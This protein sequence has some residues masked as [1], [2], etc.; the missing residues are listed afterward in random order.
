MRRFGTARRVSAHDFLKKALDV[1]DE[2][3]RIPSEMNTITTF[4][5]TNSPLLNL[6]AGKT[7]LLIALVALGAFYAGK[8]TARAARWALAL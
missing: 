5:T 1:G 7:A 6:S 3:G 8:L 4:L 2:S